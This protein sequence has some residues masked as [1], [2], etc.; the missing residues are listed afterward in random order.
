MRYGEFLLDKEFITTG[1][2]EDALVMQMD[3]PE[4]KLG[5]ILIAIGALNRDNMIS[6]LKSYIK[7]T[8]HQLKE[9][10][11]WVTQEEADMLIKEMLAESR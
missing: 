8:G 4:L 9:I 10:N 5:E 7:D 6:T 1:Q 3:N 11:N 2:L